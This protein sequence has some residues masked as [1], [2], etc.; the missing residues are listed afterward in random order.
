MTLADVSGH[1]ISWAHLCGSHVL[2]YFIVIQ[3]I[4]H[5][6]QSPGL[7]DIIM[8]LLQMRNLRPRKGK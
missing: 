5:L 4:F 2:F 3:V 8:S 1:H 7:S 6:T